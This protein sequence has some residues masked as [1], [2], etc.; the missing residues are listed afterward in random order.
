[1]R[2]DPG[3]SGSEAAA[4]PAAARSLLRLTASP[5]DQGAASNLYAIIYPEL[6][7][8]AR[9]LMAGQRSGHTL[10]PTALVN[11]AYLK[12]VGAADLDWQGR[13]H[14]RRIAAKAMRQIL[15]NYARDRAAAK[16]GGGWQRVTVSDVPAGDADRYLD[17]LALDHALEKLADRSARMAEVVELRV[18]A[19]MTAQEAAHALGV[20]K[21]TVDNDLRLA[22]LWLTDELGGPGSTGA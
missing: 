7:A 22:R 19:G 16:R 3:R 18:F 6:R 11:E 15:V 21:R 10:Q 17:V 4:D 2:D 9:R 5:D 13:S 1:M 12:L 20:S 14:F 8:I